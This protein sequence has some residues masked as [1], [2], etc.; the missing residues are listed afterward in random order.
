MIRKIRVIKQVGTFSNFDKGSNV[1]I[2]KLWFCYGRNTYGKSTLCDIFKSAGDNSDELISKRRTIPN[3]GDIAQEIILSVD[4]DGPEGVGET[5]VIYKD[6]KW[7]NNLLA[8]KIDVF[9]TSFVHRNIFNNTS[10]LG[11]RQTKENFTD[12][13]LG[14]ESVKI[15]EELTTKKQELSKMSR[16]LSDK[17]RELAHKIRPYAK[18]RG[19]KIEQFVNLRVDQSLED[20]NKTLGEIQE[21]ISKV[22]ANKNDRT[23]ILQM[24]EPSLLTPPE[25]TEILQRLQ[26]FND[27]LEK[28]YENLDEVALAHL[29]KHI[30]CHLSK[31]H[32]AQGWIEAGL[33]SIADER[34]ASCPFCGQ[35]L[36]NAKELINTYRAYFNEQYKEYVRS[37]EKTYTCLVSL[38][39]RTLSFSQDVS[40]QLI[41]L[42][43]YTDRMVD[44]SFLGIVKT[45]EDHIEGFEKKEKRI[46]G[47]LR[48]LRQSLTSCYEQ[49]KKNTYSS[50]SGL[51]LDIVKE[52]FDR[53]LIIISEV[54]CMFLVV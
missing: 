52:E 41:L 39:D 49:K 8:N 6:G 20:I 45:L 16:E 2:G 44:P 35:S 3:N 48:D 21:K 50:V 9:N 18:D 32:D 27:L 51:E 13:I 10:L 11:D 5:N 1:E 36:A 47:L 15:A 53:F 14:E 17:K 29:E 34:V 30:R 28:D 25:L 26:E 40:T 31:V 38:L 7:S 24:K 12:F 37:I 43:S 42:R 4:K 46:N 19:E 54:N 23:K 22:Q 33:S